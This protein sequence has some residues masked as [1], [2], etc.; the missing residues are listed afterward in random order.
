MKKYLPCLIFAV[1]T[2]AIMFPLY[3]SGFVF[4]LDMIFTPHSNFNNYI[5]SGTSSDLPIKI[6][7]E[8]FSF[9][10][11]LEIIQ[12]IILSL[13][14][15]LPGLLMYKLTKL[16]LPEKWAI[17]S[18]I[19]Y[20]L[21][22]FVYERFLAGHWYVLL[23]Y[24]FFPLLVKLFLEFLE[25][26]NNKNF[27]KFAFLFSVFPILSLHWAYIS[28]GF[29]LILATVYLFLSP[30]KEI[31]KLAK[32]SILLILSFLIINSFWLLNFFSPSG[33]Y[34]K[35]SLNDFAAFT[36]KADPN[37]GVLFNVLSLYGFWGSDFFL[38]KDFSPYWWIL[39]LIIL[40]FS[41]YGIYKLFFVNKEAKLPCR[42]SLASKSLALTLFIIFIPTV[43]LSIGYSSEITKPIIN[44][45]YEFLPGFKGLRETE[46]LVGLIAFSYAILVPIGG[47]VY[48]KKQKY[49]FAL[50]ILIPFLS[51]WTIFWGFNRQ[52]QS[53]DYPK[54]WYQTN[55]ILKEDENNKLL[56]L[57]WH[58]YPNVPFA[59]NA[60]IS[61][62]ASKFFQ[63]EVIASKS[64]DSVYLLELD[65]GIWDKKIL[66]L[67]HGL[68]TLDE[69][70]EF[71]QSENI[72]HI[73][74]A[75]FP[76]WE[77]YGFLEESNKLQ[78]TFET[79]DLVLYKI[80]Y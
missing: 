78:K 44:F 46:K 77:R 9:I 56:F 19:F 22:P 61:N 68:E 50:L 21:N 32:Y 39:T 72:T 38:P 14:L 23:G 79:N 3:Q 76:N 66:A 27:L 73:M 35:F 36:T 6:L 74:L 70:T 24:A 15:F 4:L 34:Y 65:Q 67:L 30:A 29:L 10:L 58:G 11:P 47:F 26:S 48:A 17:L 16:F 49:I 1:I 60:I 8:L 75:K 7:I 2:L 40:F 42:G 43:L 28:T 59:N 55:Q 13:V 80:N 12:K 54:S 64:I 25:K 62:P 5:N 18:G 57:P 71:L 63:I 53:N 41:I 33:N 31:K 51:T 37:F 20:M 69:N 45:L 52:L